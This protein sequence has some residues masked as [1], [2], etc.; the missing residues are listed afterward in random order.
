MLG[1]ELL[2]H[3]LPPRRADVHVWPTIARRARLDPLG[4]LPGTVSGKMMGRDRVALRR[5][6]CRRM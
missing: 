5:K 1:A 6:L 2:A 3:L 4:P